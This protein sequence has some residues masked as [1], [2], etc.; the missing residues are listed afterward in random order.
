M[1]RR[2]S[3]MQL[4]RGLWE[5]L[6]K[7]GQAMDMDLDHIRIRILIH[8]TTQLDMVHRL[9]A[10]EGTIP[11][12]PIATTIIITTLISSINHNSNNSNRST[13]FTSVK[14]NTCSSNNSNINSSRSIFDRSTARVLQPLDTT[15]PMQQ[16]QGTCKFQ[17]LLLP[18][19]SL[20]QRLQL[21][22]RQSPLG[23]FPLLTS[24]STRPSIHPRPR[25]RP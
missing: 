21:F 8:N 14:N 17:G 15:L 12:A 5:G 25:S 16:P 10:Q 2:R 13:L 19:L 24:P 23:S 18:L 3:I 11:T 7:I 1:V 9:S 20:R 22:P 4:S 6:D